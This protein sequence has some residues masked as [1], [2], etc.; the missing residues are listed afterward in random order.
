MVYLTT[1]QPNMHFLTKLLQ[2][3]PS[4]PGICKAQLT[5]LMLL[6]CSQSFA[7]NICHQWICEN[8]SAFNCVLSYMLRIMSSVLQGTLA[9]A[10]SS[11]VLFFLIVGTSCACAFVLSVLEQMPCSWFFICATLMKLLPHEQ[12][13]PWNKNPSFIGKLMRLTLFFREGIF[14]LDFITDQNS[15][16]QTFF[17]SKKQPL[18]NSYTAYIVLN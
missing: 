8:H 15:I 2:I 1:L 4:Y 16:L 18:Y 3:H 17:C 12:V 6:Q 5:L 9:Q 13:V 14:L 11:P 7:L 10:T